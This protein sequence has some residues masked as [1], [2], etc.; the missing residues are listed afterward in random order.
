MKIRGYTKEGG[1][2]V[3]ELIRESGAEQ[4]E[5]SSG[6]QGLNES[7]MLAYR[8]AKSFLLEGIQGRASLEEAKN[9]AV[10]YLEAAGFEVFLED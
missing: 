10:K 7:Q 6:A 2:I 8:R 1:G 9:A 5:V 4:G 3:L